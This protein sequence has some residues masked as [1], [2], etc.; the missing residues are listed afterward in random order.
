M[1]GAEVGFGI[2]ALI[3]PCLK[4]GDKVIKVCRAYRAADPEVRER[5]TRLD[6]CWLR[7]SEQLRFIERIQEL[8]DSEHLEVYK[9]AIE[10][11][12]GKL[13]A[14]KASIGSVVRIKENDTGGFDGTARKSSFAIL[15]SSIDKG[16]RELEEWQRVADPSWFLIL[17]IAKPEIDRLLGDSSRLRGAIPSAQSVRDGLR[18][19]EPPGISIF[20]P[21]GEL[22]TATWRVIS[23]C[24]AKLAFRQ[25][26][27][28]PE[29]IDSVPCLDNPDYAEGLKKDVRRLA[30]KLQYTEPETFGLLSCKGVVKS[31]SNR[32]IPT[33]FSFVFKVPRGLAMEP[34][35]L[36]DLLLDGQTRS[37]G[38][39]QGSAVSLSH[40][41]ALAKDIAKAVSYVHTFG[42]VHKNIRPETILTFP[43]AEPPSSDVP[44]SN[45]TGGSGRGGD[46]HSDDAIVEGKWS[47][48]LVGFQNVRTSEGQTYRR[49]DGDWE[50]NLY[51]HGAR[52]GIRP[53]DKYVMQHDIYSLG[54]CLLEIGLWRSLVEYPGADGSSP[55]PAAFLEGLLPRTRSD[56]VAAPTDPSPPAR[57][58]YLDTEKRLLELARKALPGKMGTLYAR[59]TETCLTCLSPDNAD[60][61]DEGE[62]QDEDEIIVAVRY[63]EK[64][65]IIRTPPKKI[66]TPS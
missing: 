59:V 32:R 51:R 49:G 64:V 38:G 35:S 66:V 7:M 54:V 39:N 56:A 65:R 23:F 37:R 25:G 28:H 42:F 40:R 24:D 18:S 62:F 1:S 36:R 5:I 46:E 8:L 4:C 60:F 30:R 17:K 53:Q 55:T 26:R 61:G 57:Q 27:T 52:Q 48:F 44:A 16:I 45:S 50:K 19:E 33:G 21:E 41:L 10:K 14:V 20:M 43:A 9:Q 2:A 58:R 3:G 6:L 15:K 34:R 29:I 31:G 13:R 22:L 47:A 63:I 11:L 12:D